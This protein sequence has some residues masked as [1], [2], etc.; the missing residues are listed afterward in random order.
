[1]LTQSPVGKEFDRKAK[2]VINK[3]I[4]VC[5]LDQRLINLMAVAFADISEDEWGHQF[6]DWCE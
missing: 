1:M 6:P 3:A 5:Q 2:L 4:K